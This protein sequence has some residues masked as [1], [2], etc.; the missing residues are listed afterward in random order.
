MADLSPLVK[1]FLRRCRRDGNTSYLD[2]LSDK[3]LASISDRGGQ[4]IAT[5]SANG[6]SYSFTE[7]AGCSTAAVLAAKETA[8]ALWAEYD[9]DQ[10]ALILDRA[11]QRKTIATFTTRYGSGFS[12]A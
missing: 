11:P 4:V 10:L 6:Q 2:K 9:T 5:G 8:Y 7:L 12:N 1:T 3:F